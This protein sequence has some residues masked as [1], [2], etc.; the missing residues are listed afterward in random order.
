MTLQKAV[1]TFSGCANIS[2]CQCKHKLQATGAVFYQ[3]VGLI[4]CANC[5]GWQFIKKRVRV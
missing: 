5:W 4:Q 1:K 3:S 2:E